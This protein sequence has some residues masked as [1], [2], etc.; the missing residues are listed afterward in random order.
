MA[1]ELGEKIDTS[2]ARVWAAVECTRK[3][4]LPIG[5]ALTLSESTRDG[6]AL[7]R[8][9]RT[10]VATWTGSVSGIDSDVAFAFLLGERP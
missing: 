2:A 4:G 1:G 6:W 8:A 3:A 5:E 10:A 9:G 7:L